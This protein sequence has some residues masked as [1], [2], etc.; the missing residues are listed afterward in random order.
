[1]T[2]LVTKS[3][4]DLQ[5]NGYKY[6][7]GDEYPRHGLIVSDARIAELKSKNNKRGVPV[8][9]AKRNKK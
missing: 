4:R 8:I 1:M 2:Y 3:F 7:A 5:D 6:V 9:K